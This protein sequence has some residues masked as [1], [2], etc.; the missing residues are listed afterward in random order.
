MPVLGICYGM[1]WITQT[2]GGKVETAQRREYG[3]AQLNLDHGD[4]ASDIFCGSAGVAASVEQP[5][6]SRD[7]TARGISQRWGMTENAVAAVE[8]PARK[9]M[10]WSFIPK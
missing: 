8:D 1:Q 10:R 4:A 5:R 9:F 2:L 6:R 3:R 7:G